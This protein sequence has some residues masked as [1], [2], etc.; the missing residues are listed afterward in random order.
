MDRIELA[1]LLPPI[2]DDANKYTRGSLLILAGS[3]RYPGAAVL[4]A[5]A[6]ARTGAGYVTLAT[7]PAVAAAVR[8]QAPTVPLV[9]L[10]ESPDGG[11]LAGRDT[12]HTLCD[13][14]ADANAVLLGPGLGRSPELMVLLRELVAHMASDSERF[15]A[16]VLDADALFAFSGEELDVLPQT[17]PLVLT[18]HARELERLTGSSDPA[19]ARDLAV[20]ER[21]VA[22][23][24]PQTH[25]FAQDTAAIETD[26]PAC[27]ATAG[28]G[29]V[30]A[31]IIVA[32]LAQRMELFQAACLGV[33]LQ[34]KAA[35]A[36]SA[37]L[38]P[39]CMNAGDLIDY[40]PLAASD[41][42]TV[43]R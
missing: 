30:L 17:H 4:A 37:A 7:V 16:L 40:L 24:G 43:G 36:A 18:P 28:S 41:L 32:L 26:A 22:A 9:E 10:V 39:F 35:A 8:G 6:A 33:R 21:V 27:L 42:L 38:T 15:P 20:G 23:K 29:D 19:S 11:I 25:L 1:A 3:A 12:R 31:G 13:L 2:A 14:A 5:R 34:T